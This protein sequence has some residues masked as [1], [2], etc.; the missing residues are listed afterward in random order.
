MCS[1]CVTEQALTLSFAEFFFGCCEEE[2]GVISEDLV[3][4]VVAFASCRS[5]SSPLWIL[6]SNRHLSGWVDKAKSSEAAEQS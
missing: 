6:S 1:Y 2:P 5:C 3:E 4:E